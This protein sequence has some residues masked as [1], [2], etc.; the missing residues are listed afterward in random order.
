MELERLYKKWSLWRKASFNTIQVPLPEVGDSITL[1][2]V[3]HKNK[4]IG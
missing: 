3:E 1:V 2:D 4:P